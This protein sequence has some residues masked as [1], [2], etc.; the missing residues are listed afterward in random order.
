MSSLIRELLFPLTLSRDI[1]FVGVMSLSIAYM[2]MLSFRH[3]TLQTFLPELIKD[4]LPLRAEISW[5]I[6]R[7]STVSPRLDKTL[8][9]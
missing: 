2:V 9:Y 4:K 7:V 1:F 5:A 3:N 6:S 8:C